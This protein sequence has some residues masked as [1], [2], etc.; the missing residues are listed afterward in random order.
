MLGILDPQEVFLPHFCRAH[1]FTP[2]SSVFSPHNVGKKLFPSKSML[3]ASRVP[4]QILGLHLFS[5]PHTNA[6]TACLVYQSSGDSPLVMEN[7]RDLGVTRYSALKNVSMRTARGISHCSVCPFLSPEPCP[8]HCTHV[9]SESSW[10][11]PAI[12]TFLLEISEMCESRKYVV[13]FGRGLLFSE[14]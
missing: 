13:C 14:R 4:S 3:L 8:L 10:E 2:F 1:Y 7:K 5:R 11:V 9:S 6:P 12:R